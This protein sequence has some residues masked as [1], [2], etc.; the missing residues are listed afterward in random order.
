[1]SAQ[2]V[3]WL[4]GPGV[5]QRETK[6]S[7]KKYEKDAF[8][9]KRIAVMFAIERVLNF[10]NYHLNLPGTE[11]SRKMLE[12]G[13]T[14]A[15]K[16]L[17]YL[18]DNQEAQDVPL[19]QVLSGY[20]YVIRKKKKINVNFI[21]DFIPY[22]ENVRDRARLRR[23]WNVSANGLS[24]PTFLHFLIPRNGSSLYSDAFY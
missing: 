2:E 15:L 17:K 3:N 6:V 19:N 18:E 13:K 11:Y 12:N 20:K 23:T 4:F 22:W 8:K 21:G 24:H 14:F 1:M 16:S 7:P 10:C 9:R 5:L